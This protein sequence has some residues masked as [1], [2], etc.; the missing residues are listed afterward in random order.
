MLI[1]CRRSAGHEK[2]NAEPYLPIHVPTV[3]RRISNASGRLKTGDHLER[4]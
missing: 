3:S 4:G 1:D 2:P